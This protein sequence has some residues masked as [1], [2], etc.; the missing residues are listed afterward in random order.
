LCVTHLPQ[1]AAYADRHLAIRK[2]VV[3]GRTVTRVEEIR[4]ARRVDEIAQ[5]LGSV[6]DTT[7]E[8]AQEMLERV[9]SERR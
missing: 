5:M 6:T 2:E 7:R 9:K 1:I 4:D 8:S 3:A